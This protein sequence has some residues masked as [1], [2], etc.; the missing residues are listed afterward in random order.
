MHG[1]RFRIWTPTSGHVNHGASE[2]IGSIGYILHWKEAL[3]KVFV[4]I[5][6]KALYARNE[7]SDIDSH[8]R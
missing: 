2:R 8:M 1:T 5:H 7:I 3:W 6:T 4:V